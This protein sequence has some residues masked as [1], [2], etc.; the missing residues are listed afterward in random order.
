MFW[1]KRFHH[2]TMIWLKLAY[3]MSLDDTHM[4][5]LI[6]L[7]VVCVILALWISHS[8]QL[9]HSTTESHRC[10]ETSSC[11]CVCRKCTFRMWKY[12]FECVCA[13][14]YT[15]GC[16][17]SMHSTLDCVFAFWFWRF[18]SLLSF[19]QMHFLPLNGWMSSQSPCNSAQITWADHI[20]QVIFRS[21][22][23]MHSL[24]QRMF[25]TWICISSTNGFF[26]HSFQ[27]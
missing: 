20:F 25:F 22:L 8:A 2:Y 12:G 24:C 11:S 19:H 23:P 27:L 15:H 10:S 21:M 13:F 16:R 6:L 5:A 14:S 18:S 3:R 26:L 4:C 7:T 9:A 1:I 17:R